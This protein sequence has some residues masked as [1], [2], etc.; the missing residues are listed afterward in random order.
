MSSSDYTTVLVKDDRIGNIRDDIKYAVMKGG[1]TITPTPYKAISS[2]TSSITFNVQVPSQETIIS[3]EL[4]LKSTCKLQLT[5]RNN[6]GAALPAYADA[7]TFF[8]AVMGYGGG[9]SAPPNRACALA[10]FPQHQLFSVMTSTINNTSVSINIRDVLP[11]ILR[12]ND[13]RQ[14]SQYNSTA[15]IMYDTYGNYQNAIGAVNNPLGSWGNSADNDLNPRGSWVLDAVEAGDGAVFPLTLAAGAS[16]NLNIKF[17]TAEPLLLSPWIFANSP[18]SNQGFYGIQVCNFVFNIG[19]A[20]RVWRD[21]SPANSV[22]LT[23]CT[24]LE[25]TDSTLLFTFI[26]PHP[27]ELLSARNVVPYMEMPRYLTQNLNAIATDATATLNT[28]TLQLNQVPDK[29]IVMVRKRMDLQSNGDADCFLP[30]TKLSVNFNTNAGILSSA[31]QQDLYKACVRSGSNQSWYEF[32]GYANSGNSGT[33]TGKVITSGSCLILDFGT[34]IQL[35]DEFYAP[36]SLGSFNLQMQIDVKNNTGADIVN[37]TYE[38][39][40]ITLNSGVFVTERGTSQAFTGILSKAQV[41]EASAGETYTRSD[42]Q[43][44]VGGG[45]FDGLKSVASKV[46]DF[47]APVAKALAPVAKVALSSMPDPRAQV[48]AQALGALGA[49]QSGGRRRIADSRI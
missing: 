19:N 10:P 27:S 6:T 15:P 29:L 13:K 37:N 26:T 43:R 41:L 21:T 42:V 17:T 24:L 44:L 5:Y 47:V 34:E 45:F 36:G 16:V 12:F 30:I 46:K 2:G 4:M 49:G 8:N 18:Y 40:L 22:N 35:I 3:R 38:I 23:S 31:S 20:S 28:Q 32:S 1:Q 48:A 33:A 39:C 11:A 7:Q 9:A 14:L 25:V